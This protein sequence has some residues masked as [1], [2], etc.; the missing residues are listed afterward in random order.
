[1]IKLTCIKN[2]NLNGKTYLAG[3]E[4]ETDDFR[5]INKLNELGYV[6]TLTIS[7]LIRKEKQEKE[8]VKKD[9]TREY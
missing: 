1:M 8:E 7:D 3:D 5:V 6:E 9:D 2:F 4:I